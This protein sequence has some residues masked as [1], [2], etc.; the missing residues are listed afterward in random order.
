MPEGPLEFAAETPR[1]RDGARFDIF[2]DPNDLNRGRLVPNELT[3][4]Y[5][6]HSTGYAEVDGVTV[7][8]LWY[9]LAPAD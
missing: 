4:R 7:L 1:L 3:G 8:R 2:T 9:E 5:V 6:V